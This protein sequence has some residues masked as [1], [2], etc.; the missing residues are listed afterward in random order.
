MRTQK[1]AVSIPTEI[2]A[3]AEAEAQRRGVSRSELYT[4]A[5]D[6]YLH[7]SAQTDITRRLD[8]VYA[9]EAGT[10]DPALAAAQAEVLPDERWR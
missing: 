9:E 5:L 8:A 6:E 1:T 4:T 3:Q 2:F 7:R 10:L